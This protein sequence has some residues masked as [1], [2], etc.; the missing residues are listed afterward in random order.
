MA[1]T[2]G[3]TWQKPSETKPQTIGKPDG[4]C[5]QRNSFTWAYSRIMILICSDQFK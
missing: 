4:V 5:G 3:Q 2:G 1:G